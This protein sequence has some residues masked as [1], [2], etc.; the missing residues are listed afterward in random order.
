[1]T[2]ILLAIGISILTLAIIALFA[3]SL[4]MLDYY[5]GEYS[6]LILLFII[7][8]ILIY[9]ILEYDFGL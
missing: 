4:I 5:F 3:W 8:T 6:V 1:M 7:L 9:V 2:T